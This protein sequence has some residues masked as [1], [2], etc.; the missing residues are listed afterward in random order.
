MGIDLGCKRI[1][2]IVLNPQGHAH[3]R[4]QKPLPAAISYETA[5]LNISAVYQELLGS[6]DPI[7]P[8]LG[9]SVPGDVCTSTG[10]QCYSPIAY[11]NDQALH[12][13]LQGL[14]G[15][16]L[17]LE[18]DSTC[19]TVAEAQCGAGAGYANVLG[20]VLDYG[21]NAGVTTRGR[22]AIRRACLGNGW[23]HTTLE[24]HGPACYCG[25]R[26]CIERYLSI[27]ALENQFTQWSGEHIASKDIVAR[28]HAGDSI[29]STVLKNY[30]GHFTVAVANITALTKPHVIVVGGELASIDSIYR[31]DM[32]CPYSPLFN[33]ASEVPILRS[34]LVNTAAATGAALLGI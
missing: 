19:F 23:G 15:R 24:T 34:K 16:E 30:M 9:I 2:G 22:P 10:R 4:V 33:G 20:I 18:S 26:G 7:A 32:A 14:V 13:D 25:R 6:A 1:E 17:V 29:A 3:A 11:L 8:T 27:A 21:V 5:L 12:S 31:A 28:S